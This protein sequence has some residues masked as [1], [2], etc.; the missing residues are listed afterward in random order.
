MTARATAQSHAATIRDE[1]AAGA[2]TAT[3]VGTN[4]RELADGAAFTED[5]GTTIADATKPVL[6]PTVM[7]TITTGTT[8]PISFTD[9]LFTGLT[10]GGAASGTTGTTGVIGTSF[11]SSGAET[12]TGSSQ[13][14]LGSAASSTQPYNTT[15]FVGQRVHCDLRKSNSEPLVLSDV[16]T[17]AA[18]SYPASVASPVF[19]YLAYRS[20]LGANLK[21][22]GWF[23]FRDQ[24]TGNLT[25]VTPDISVAT[26][27]LNVPQVVASKDVPT[28]ALY[29]PVQSLGASEVIFGA[30]ADIQA[31]GTAAGG[32]SGKVADAK[33]VHTKPSADQLAA[34]AAD[35]S[36]NGHK[37]TSVANGA[38]ATDVAAF[39][40]IPVIANAVPQAISYPAAI[41]ASG[42]FADMNHVHAHPLSSARLGFHCD[43]LSPT[44]ASFVTSTI[45][46][47]CCGE[48][49]W[50]ATNANS[51]TGLTDAAVNNTTEVGV[52]TIATGA[53]T[54]GASTLAAWGSTIATGISVTL[55]SANPFYCGWKV[56][57]STAVS[58]GT[59]TYL[60]RVG[61]MDTVN[62]A[63][64][65]GLWFEWDAN[66]D[67]HFKTK[68]CSG[69]A[70]NVVAV[71]TTT[72]VA[73][74]TYHILEMSKPAGS[75]TVTF[76]I[77]GVVQGST[78]TAPT[79]APV[80][81]LAMIVKSAGGT[82]RALSIDWCDFEHIWATPRT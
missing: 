49:N 3:R 21:W 6:I 8:Q 14:G 33:H 52:V 13:G 46:E 81:P 68:T 55:A 38:A 19:L 23:Y 17:T 78:G 51:A 62:A 56:A 20:D 22:R 65:N 70:G 7:G 67:T 59:N 5:I 63:P 73:S 1:A 75:T 10:A 24:A 27:S 4:L 45:Y 30:T 64:A 74:T 47:G 76:T 61:L 53:Q 80:G 69:G 58:D 32:T 26:V 25:P 35:F 37:G 12:G 72:I 57:S 42:Q 34:T 44:S 40:Q 29:V 2:N 18:A 71:Q 36:F 31:L 50:S 66:T 79:A 48:P 15:D 9:A 41:G 60:C 16:L 11:A 77:D 28:N 39:G 54:N 43:F 82:G